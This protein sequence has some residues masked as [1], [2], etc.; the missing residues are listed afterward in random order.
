MPH[1]QPIPPGPTTSSTMNP[2]IHGVIRKGKKLAEM[3]NPR[4]RIVEMSD[5]TISLRTLAPVLQSVSLSPCQED[6]YRLSDVCKDETSRIG[7]ERLRRRA[8]D[9]SEKIAYDAE[10]IALTPADDGRQ[11]RNGRL[12]DGEG[13]ASDDSQRRKPCHV[14]EGRRSVV[15]VVWYRQRR[16]I[17]SEAANSLYIKA[18]SNW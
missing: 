3:A 10:D 7:P 18:L 12:E 1:C 15:A 11:L 4:Q 14:V 9:V 2:E 5:M 8:Q 6:S 13:D 16:S 17:G